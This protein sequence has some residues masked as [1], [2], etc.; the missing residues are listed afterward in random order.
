MLNFIL[1]S[2]R[3]KRQI[4][5]FLAT[6]ERRA[7]QV[8]SQVENRSEESCGFAKIVTRGSPVLPISAHGPHVPPL[9]VALIDTRIRSPDLPLP[10]FSYLTFMVEKRQVC[11]LHM[12]SQILKFTKIGSNYNPLFFAPILM[13]SLSLI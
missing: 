4:Y 2:S 12:L 9:P 10:N 5:N 13:L 7:A 3:L 6:L 11:C 8:D 1:H